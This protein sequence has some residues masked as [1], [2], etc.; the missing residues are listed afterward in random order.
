MTDPPNDDGEV[1]ERFLA[2]IDEILASDEFRTPDLPVSAV[3]HRSTTRFP[4]R[5]VVYGAIAAAVVAL[6]LVGVA[7]IQNTDLPTVDTERAA[8]PTSPATST[9]PPGVAGDAARAQLAIDAEIA[10]D[11]GLTLGPPV[12]DDDGDFVL[13]DQP[14]L[15]PVYD[16][17]VLIG[18]ARRIDH[19]PGSESTR[20]TV[21]GPDGVTVRGLYD[22]QTGFVA[23]DPTPQPGD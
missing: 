3:E 22:E 13:E 5:V 7:A 21:Y 14:D 8:I 17:D 19:D 4:T 11:L 23:I 2:L 18:Y 20:I 1:P 6:A 12:F 9:P 15:T 16:L 10:A